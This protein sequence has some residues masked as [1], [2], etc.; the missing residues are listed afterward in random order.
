MNQGLPSNPDIKYPPNNEGRQAVPFSR[1]MVGI[2][3]GE[4]GVPGP[5]IDSWAETPADGASL[6]SSNN[7]EINWNSAPASGTFVLASVD[8]TIQWL[9][10]EAC[11]E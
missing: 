1:P 3:F 2:P 11:E 9:A 5:L 6:L 10:T 4:N 7:G 8:G